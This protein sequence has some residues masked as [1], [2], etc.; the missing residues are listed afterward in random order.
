[1]EGNGADK[2]RYFIRDINN[3]VKS[4]F[5][6][7]TNTLD[8]TWHHLAYT[9]DANNGKFLVYVDGQPNSS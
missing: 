7:T 4:Q 3:T 9:Y 2:T 1:M 6:G 5:V 8:D